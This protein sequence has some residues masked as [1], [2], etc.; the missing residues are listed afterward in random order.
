MKIYEIDEDEFDFDE[1]DDL[2]Y[3]CGMGPDGLCSQAGSEQ[4]EFECPHRRLMH[5]VAAISRGA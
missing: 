2:F 1:D 4:C 5:V 3:D